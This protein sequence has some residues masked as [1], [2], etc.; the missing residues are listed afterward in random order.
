MAT[1]LLPTTV[2]TISPLSSTKHPNPNRLFPK[3]QTLAPFTQLTAYHST[4]FSCN[5]SNSNPNFLSTSLHDPKFLDAFHE[6]G[7]Q[8]EGEDD[9]GLSLTTMA[10]P[11]KRTSRTKSK[12]RKNCWKRKANVAAKKAFSLAKSIA[13]GN[14]KSFFVPPTTT[15]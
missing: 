7:L 12:I 4:K 6:L 1:S 15:K 13:T 10:V 9:D 8:D 14:S 2:P 11:K 5:S 3:S